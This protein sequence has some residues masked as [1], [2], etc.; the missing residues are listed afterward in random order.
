MPTPKPALAPAMP[1]RTPRIISGGKKEDLERVIRG[2]I[3][4]RAYYL[5]EGSGRE[6]GNPERH[7]LQAEAEVMQRGTLE[8]RESGTWLSI[9]ATLPGASVE[10]V[11]V[12]LDPHSVIVSMKDCGDVENRESQTQGAMQPRQY[13]VADLN[14]EVEPATAS[15]SFK[16]QKLT[17]MIKERDSPTAGVPREA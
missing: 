14:V 13:L 11:E 6:H 16:D 1:T 2:K 10:I 7:W 4:E 3:S 8:V 9:N 5:F 12:F 17:L 15:A